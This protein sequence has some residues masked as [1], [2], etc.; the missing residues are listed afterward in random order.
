MKEGRYYLLR[1]WYGDV[2]GNSSLVKWPCWR[3]G[4]NFGEPFFNNVVG[5]LN[6]RSSKKESGEEYSSYFNN[7]ASSY[8]LESGNMTCVS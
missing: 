4:R 7:P 5:Y 8:L 6:W 3:D 2:P 1:L